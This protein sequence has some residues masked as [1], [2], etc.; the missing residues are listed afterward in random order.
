MPRYSAT[1]SGRSRS[2]RLRTLLEIFAAVAMYRLVTD[3]IVPVLPKPKI[4]GCGKLK[5]LPK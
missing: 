4:F 1:P 2:D 3:K 5:A